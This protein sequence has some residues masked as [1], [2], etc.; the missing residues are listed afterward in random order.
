MRVH[1]TLFVIL[2]F[3]NLIPERLIDRKKYILP[4]S[5]LIVFVYWAIRFDYGLDYWNYLNGFYSG[6]SENRAGFGERYF[7][8]LMHLFKYYYQ[9]IIVHSAIVTIS[10]YYLVRKHISP[11][12]YWIFFVLL[13]VVP[14]FHF[15]LISAQRSTLAA[16]V[17]YWGFELF[18]I[19][20]KKWLPFIAMVFLAAMFHTSAILFLSIPLLYF[21]LSRVSGSAVFLILVVSTVLSL[22]ITDNL[23][24]FIVNSLQ[25]LMEY[26]YYSDIV[27]TRSF[28]AMLVTSVRLI[29]CWF[30]CKQ[31]R[32]GDA[33]FDRIS[34]LAFAYLIILFLY[35]NF[36]GR[37]TVYLIPFFIIV[38]CKTVELSNKNERYIILLPFF[39]MLG[40]TLYMY[41]ETLLDGINTQW[42]SGN[43]YFYHT[44]FE[45]P[46][47]P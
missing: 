12:T 2:L 45:A 16:C 43:M 14:D 20:D 33:V 23:Y 39:L 40:Y 1:L 27:G 26:D 6:Q 24:I 9:W 28:S 8:Y 15:N 19:R 13:F 18:Y 22:F 37:F 34:V 46:S 3:L 11:K 44:I 4:F 35:I 47:L 5:F 7:Y 29:P 32:K 21:L 25:I 36:Q 38:L 42:S 41:Y 10:L 31:Y 17:L 30:I